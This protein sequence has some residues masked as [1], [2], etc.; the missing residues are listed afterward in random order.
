MGQDS[1]MTYFPPIQI[2][3]IGSLYY[4][5]MAAVTGVILFFYFVYIGK[6]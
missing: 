2:D 5:I 3:I 4:R 6:R 1:H